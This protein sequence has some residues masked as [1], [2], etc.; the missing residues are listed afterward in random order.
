MP[1]EQQINADFLVAF[2]AKDENAVKV[3]RMAKAALLNRKIEQKLAK[4]EILTEAE[5]QAVIRSEIKKRRDSLAAYTAGGR[6]DLAEAE[7]T[8]INILE[9]YLP[10]QLSDEQVKS[11]VDE[12]VAEIGASKSGLPA[13]RQAAFGQVMGLVMKKAKGQA[14]GQTVSHL[15]KEALG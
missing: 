3:L 14:D 6:Q 13:G 10:A 1:L 2:K 9:K 7:Q 5:A 15:V 8:E 11:L 4:E 12:A